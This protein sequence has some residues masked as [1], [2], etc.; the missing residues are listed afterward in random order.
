MGFEKGNCNCF[1]REV[2]ALSISAN[3]SG[4]IHLN[5]YHI[6]IIK[7]LEKFICGEADSICLLPRHCYFKI[8][9]T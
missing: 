6:L 3:L 1:G 9:I 7:V 2:N 4:T 5:F 8:Y